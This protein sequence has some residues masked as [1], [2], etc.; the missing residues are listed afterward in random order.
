MIK[1]T[2][3]PVFAFITSIVTLF[4]V[5]GC[6]VHVNAHEK[7]S[8]KSSYTTVNKKVSVSDGAKADEISSVNGKVS[9][10]DN[11]SAEEISSVNGKIDIGENLTAEEVST[12]NGKITIGEGAKISKSVESVNGKI[13]ISSGSEIDGDIITVNGTVDLDG[14]TVG[15]NLESVNGNL[16]LSKGTVIEGDII[17]HW[18]NNNSSWRNKSPTLTID[19]SSTVNGEIVI[20]HEVNFEF[21]DDSLMQKV[22]NKIDE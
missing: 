14:V 15:G 21:A 2:K 22:V 5:T 7:H 19:S 17:F 20:Y 12:V 13:D 16:T 11:V 3:K 8:E 18:N 6:V 1:Q 9:V 4:M 10:G